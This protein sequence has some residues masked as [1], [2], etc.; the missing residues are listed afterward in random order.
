M[1]FWEILTIRIVAYIVLALLLCGFYA[2]A[3]AQSR[4]V[5]QNQ[6]TQVVCTTTPTVQ[7]PSGP[8]FDPSVIG[9]IGNI[10]LSPE[11]IRYLRIR[12][13]IRQSQQ[14]GLNENEIRA[15]CLR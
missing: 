4:T 10:Q 1:R 5:C 6:G 2:I 9:S 13:C 11:E 15:R 3:H 14:W 8:G 7:V 12:Q